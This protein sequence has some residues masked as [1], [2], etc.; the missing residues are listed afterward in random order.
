MKKTLVTALTLAMAAPMVLSSVANAE[1][2]TMRI[3]E[4][5]A[6][7]DS[8]L[9]ATQYAVNQFNETNEYNV[10]LEL[11]NLANADY[12]TKLS[13]VMA[14]DSEPDIF[15]TWELGYLK[16]FINGDKVIDLQ[17]YLDADPEWRDSFNAGILDPV[18]YDGDVYAIPVT[19]TVAMM[20]YNEEI[21]EQQGLTVPTTIEELEA[22][23]DQLKEAGITPIALGG[24]SEDAWLVSQIIQEL[25]NGIAGYDLYSGIVDGSRN[26]NDPAFIDAAELLQKWIDAGYFEDGFTGVG[27]NEARALFQTGMTA[28]YYN[29]GWSNATL[30]DPGATPIYGKVGVFAMPA[31][32]QE[33]KGTIMGSVNRTYAISK[34]CQNIEAAV[35]FLKYMTSEEFQDLLIYDYAG[36]PTT[37]VTVDEEKLSPLGNATIQ[38]VSEQQHLTAWFD[39][40]DTNMGNEFNNSASAIANGEDPQET[41]DALQAFYENQ[42]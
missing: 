28:M 17:E 30:D 18:T 22:V 31:S 10:T 34:N 33:N 8:I 2:I 40:V 6:E 38:L 25:S 42:K 20:Y 5:A 9:K 29:G 11:E 1:E 27:N 15:Y 14:A 19:T 41:Y 35:A 37:N 12:K 13:T 32:N 24:T 23:C 39:R 21:F 16:N 3:M 26:W 36:L 7:A 4:N